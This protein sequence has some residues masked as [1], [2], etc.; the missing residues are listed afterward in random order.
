MFFLILCFYNNSV[1]LSWWKASSANS[2]TF[3]EYW[4]INFNE[5]DMNFLCDSDSVFDFW[6]CENEPDRLEKF[7]EWEMYI[8]MY[9]PLV[10]NK[11]FHEYCFYTLCT[12]RSLNF[13]PKVTLSHLVVYP[14]GFAD[15][16]KHTLH[17]AH[18]LRSTK[19]TC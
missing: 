16:M 17:H 12:T 1:S 19:R 5:F 3:F 6:F 10:A 18:S 9:I 14:P 15:I 2:W 13:H 7:I 4:L 8:P 11:V